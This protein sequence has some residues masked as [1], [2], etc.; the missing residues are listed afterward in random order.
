MREMPDALNEQHRRRGVEMKEKQE[1][2]KDLNLLES[3]Q[4]EVKTENERGSS[5]IK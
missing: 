1:A 4:R 2:R 5:G 3:I